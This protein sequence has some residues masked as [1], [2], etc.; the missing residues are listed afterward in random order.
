MGQYVGESNT[1]AC[2][3]VYAGDGYSPAQIAGKEL[4]GAYYK[5]V[6][7][8]VVKER[9]ASA[10]YRMAAYLNLIFGGEPGLAVPLTASVPMCKY[11]VREVVV[12]MWR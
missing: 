7:T 12:L 2:T 4:K 10:G 6:A 11:N 9:I 5:N 8:P 1:L 3:A